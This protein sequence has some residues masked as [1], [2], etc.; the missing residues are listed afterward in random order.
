MHPIIF[1]LGP[2]T[3]YSYGLMLFI[4]V[5]VAI[6]LLVKE[7]KRKGYNEDFI[8]NLGAIILISGIIGSRLL[9][10]LLNLEFYIK[11]PKEIVMLHHGGLAIFGGIVVAI[12]ITFMFANSKKYSFLDIADLVIPYVVL[13][14]SIGRIGCLLNGCCY[15]APCKFGLY[16]PVHSAILIPTQL[17]SSLILLILYVI[18]RLK[19]EKPHFN[20]AV[21]VNYLL[22]YSVYRFLIEF[23]RADSQRLF[24]NLTIFQYFC[25]GLFI[26]GFAL[27]SGIKW[28]RKRLK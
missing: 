6:N 20:G 4:A 1:K 27:N 11:N 26:F 2:I 18:L 22:C 16:F 12:I 10:L 5:F 25:I 28:K 13:G 17:I 8:F 14:E 23:F 7:A 3:I 19:Q 15:G 9:Y 24:L 21:F